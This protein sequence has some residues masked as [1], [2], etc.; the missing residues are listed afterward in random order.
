MANKRKSTWCFYH[1]TKRI[2]ECSKREDTLHLKREGTF[3]RGHRL[4][5]VYLVN[6]HVQKSYIYYKDNILF[7]QNMMSMH[8]VRNTT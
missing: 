4:H 3:H 2:L 6:S 5:S 8:M 7:K 1:E